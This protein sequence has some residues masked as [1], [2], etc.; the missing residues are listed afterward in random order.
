MEPFI[1]VIGFLESPEWSSC[2]IIR[3]A[4]R[5][6]TIAS[7]VIYLGSQGRTT[8]ILSEQ[9]TVS[10]PYGLPN[11]SYLPNNPAKNFTNISQSIHRRRYSSKS[12]RDSADFPLEQDTPLDQDPRCGE[13][14]HSVEIA[15]PKDQKAMSG[16]FGVPS[17][18][19]HSKEYRFQTPNY[20][21]RF[22]PDIECIKVIT[23]PLGQRIVMAFRGVF[24]LEP[25][26]HCMMDFL[27]IRD[28]AFGF[29]PLL[30]R[31]CSRR[32]PDLG[33]GLL[34]THRYMWLRF[35]SDSTIEHRGVQAIYRF[36]PAIL[37][38]AGYTAGI[39]ASRAKRSR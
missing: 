28:G 21:E 36:L 18:H 35:R 3:R 26:P 5:I 16:F 8:S 9:T 30:G 34:S 25:E 37:D 39:I 29:S 38:K 27:E 10:N 24:E 33:D 20:P 13:F 15:T 11:K 14:I 23:A 7:L 2:S 4:S 6:L 17:L 22:P 1:P 19:K 31:F 12:K 32:M